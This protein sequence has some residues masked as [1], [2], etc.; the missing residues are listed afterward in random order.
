MINTIEPSPNL[1]A[2]QF[3]SDAGDDPLRLDEQDVQTAFETHGA[4]L[5]RGFSFDVE[6]FRAFAERLCPL[7][8]FNESPD[9]RQLD[10]S[11]NIQT[12]NLGTDP[13]PLH[14]ELSREPWRPD[15][16]VFAC[17]DPPVSDGQTTFCDGTAIVQALPSALVDEMR[18]RQLL[19]IQPAGPQAL[20]YWLGSAQPNDAAL[21]SPP[22]H[23]P[24]K[25]RRIQGRIFRIFERPLLD[26]SRFGGHLVWANFLLFARDY[27][28]RPNFPCLDDGKPVPERWMELVR[29]ASQRLTHD[30]NWQKGDILIV[31]NSRFM[32]GR[33]KIT[34]PRGRSI[35]SY[36]G[37]LKGAAPLPG[38]PADPIWR[39]ERFRPPA[40]ARPGVSV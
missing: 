12:V 17:F 32:H 4:L 9:R 33:R 25:F 23:C 40:P 39:R 8:V 22:P 21:E 15:A 30:V 2:M 34:D 18:E 11:S 7:S 37:Y 19:Y 13:F 1:P 31:D 6:G 28:Q 26:R 16:C 5:L 10:P 3:L 36:F 24:Y 35:A 38:E 27:L 20:Q 29:E 14:P